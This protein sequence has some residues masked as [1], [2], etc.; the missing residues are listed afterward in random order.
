MGKN[1]MQEVNLP[2]SSVSQNFNHIQRVE[3][4]H[5]QVGFP[6]G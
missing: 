2:Q 6:V 4:S 1:M 5:K 3:V